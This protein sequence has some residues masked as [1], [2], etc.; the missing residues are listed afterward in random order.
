MIALNRMS[1]SRGQTFLINSAAAVISAPLKGES[2]WGAA[3]F[4]EVPFVPDDEFSGRMFAIEI[5]ILS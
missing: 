4:V 1:V 5:Q 2:G 3:G